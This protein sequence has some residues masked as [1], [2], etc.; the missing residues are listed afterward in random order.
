MTYFC[1]SSRQG[2]VISSAQEHH[3]LNE[4]NSAYPI[5]PCETTSTRASSMNTM[6]ARKYN[7]VTGKRTREMSIVIRRLL[8]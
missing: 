5:P 1:S 6:D 2:F 4:I 3:L 7:G 8:T